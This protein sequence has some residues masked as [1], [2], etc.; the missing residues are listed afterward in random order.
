MGVLVNQRNNP[1]I[2]GSSNSTAMVAMIISNQSAAAYLPGSFTHEQNNVPADTFKWTNGHGLTSS[3]GSLSY[4]RG[5]N[6]NE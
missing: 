4:P 5:S 2:S 3:I 6:R 1:S